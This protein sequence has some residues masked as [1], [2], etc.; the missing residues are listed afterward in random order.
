MSFNDVKTLVEHLNLLGYP[1]HVPI[2]A[3]YTPHGSVAAFQIVAD[4]LTWLIESLE[5][6]S[7]LI[8][9]TSSESERVL[10]IKSV[11][12]ILVTK[13]GIKVNPRKLYSS[14]VASAGELLKITNVLIRAPEN[15]INQEDDVGSATEI[16][17]SD[18]VDTLRRIRELSSELTVRGATLY[19]L[20]GKE[21][22]NK[23]VRN[24]Q[25]GRP[26]ELGVVERNL[27][28]AITALQNQIQSKRSQLEQSKVETANF[29]GRLQRKRQELERNQQRLSAL[30]KVRPSY[31]EEFEKLEEELKLLFESYIVKHR[32]V[33]AL[34]AALNA[35]TSSVRS[36]ENS[37]I[38]RQG[39]GDGSMTVLPDGFLMDSEDDD[40]DEDNDLMQLQQEINNGS[41]IPAAGD[42]PK[43]STLL[44]PRI[45]TGGRKVDNEPKMIDLKDSEHFSD[46]DDS[47]SMDGEG[48]PFEMEGQLD[49][50]EDA[51]ELLQGAGGGK[52][53]RQD[54]S[55]EDF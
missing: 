47:I 8:G 36:A 10:L 51:S 20:L 12:E 27:K 40:D 28:T 21:V 23:E 41:E 44:R 30:Q 1:H 2:G 54:M 6:G 24:Q 32:T 53:M 33:D 55:D 26:M 34:K 29:N 31:L 9:G 15:A 52:T 37:P 25:A 7:Q 17:L 35:R 3:L 43:S 42:R 39:G 16:D 18:K 11:A 45:R 19:D 50:D 38:S 22:V 14:S 4:I 13:A 5:P 48:Q 46:S 49:S